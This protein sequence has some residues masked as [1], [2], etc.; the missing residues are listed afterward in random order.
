MSVVVFQMGPY[1]AL[2]SNGYGDCFYQD[3]WSIVGKEVCKFVLSFLNHNPKIED[4][5]HTYLVIIQ[6]VKI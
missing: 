3:H 4:I 6:R 5:N 2:G 1:K